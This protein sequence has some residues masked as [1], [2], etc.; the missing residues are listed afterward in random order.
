M[1]KKN[2]V[3]VEAAGWLRKA[4]KHILAEP[5]RYDQDRTL[6]KVEP[7]KQFYYTTI[8][9]YKAPACGTV[10]CLAGWVTALSL[11][12]D[13]SMRVEPVSYASDKLGLNPYQRDTLFGVVERWPTKYSDQYCAAKTPK[14]VARVAARRVEHFIK[15]GE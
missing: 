8:G 14:Q 15:T 13:E 10:G 11:P 5:R 12:L 6:M 4:V 1:A 3:S 7:G 2:A 9:A